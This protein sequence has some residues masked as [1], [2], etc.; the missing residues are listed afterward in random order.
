MGVARRATIDDAD[1]VAAVLADAFLN[2]PVMSW[3]FPDMS[4]RRRLLEANFGYLAE[5][6]YLEH[7]RCRVSNNAAALWLPAGV[8]LG[9]EFWYEHRR[10]Y[11]EALDGEVGRLSAI[12]KAAAK[13]QPS[14]P[15][16]YLLAIGVRRDVQGKGEGTAMLAES[17]ADA[18]SDHEGAYL[19]ATS[20]QSRDLYQCH[21]FEVLAEVT[22]VDGPPTWPM[23][24]A[25]GGATSS[26]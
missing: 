4:A 13:H 25:P 11:V 14:D 7:G 10:P 1:F 3:A 18:D 5:H 23:W 6:A 26:G 24:R 21:G 12:G 9:I 22:V 17:L 15:H 8:R 2:D 20:A 19:E 16:R